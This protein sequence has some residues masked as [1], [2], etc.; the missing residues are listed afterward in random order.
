MN[1]FECRANMYHLMEQSTDALARQLKEHIASCTDCY[2][3]YE[4][5]Q[6]VAALFKNGKELKTPQFL[7]ASV[8]K[9]IGKIQSKKSATRIATLKKSAIGIA[10]IL[11][12]VLI[13]PFTGSNSNTARANDLLKSALAAL[14]SLRTMVMNL[15]VRTEPGENFSYIDKQGVMLPH[16]ITLD[17]KNNKWRIDKGGRIAMMKN[18]TTFLYLYEKTDNVAVYFPGNAKGVAGWFRIF[19]EPEAV[20][21]N[22]Q[23]EAVRKGSQIKIEEAGNEIHLTVTS[24]AEGNFFNDFAKNKSVKE[25]DN[26]REYVF[27]KQTHLLTSLKVYLLDGKKETLM[28][29]AENIQYDLSLNE[30]AFS[31]NLPQNVKWE[32][33]KIPTKN[34]RIDKLS[35]DE[36]A[37]LILDD[38]S[39]RDYDTHFEIWDVLPKITIKRLDDNYGGLQI[40]AIDKAFQ[41]GIYPGYF[42]RFKAKLKTG[43]IVDGHLSIRNDNKDGIWMIDGG[44]I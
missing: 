39:K 28:I 41:S 18:D 40:I 24:K 14:Q 13:I 10:A 8:L 22:E 32:E 3:E 38:I 12:L 29:A 15:D 27:D 21:K 37:R 4:R 5:M 20:L 11:I 6:D 26:R 19:L 34:D 25:S 33:F 23:E 36:V 17:I 43:K 16:K 31:V 30:T 42:V 9:E 1:C 2:N 44:I 7:K 35:A